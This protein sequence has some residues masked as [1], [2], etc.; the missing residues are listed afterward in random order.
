VWYY[1]PLENEQDLLSSLFCV[2]EIQS[3]F[4]TFTLCAKQRGALHLN[5]VK[6]N[7]NIVNTEAHKEN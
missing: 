2:E 1:F 3:T 4:G 6:Q 7:M 5:F